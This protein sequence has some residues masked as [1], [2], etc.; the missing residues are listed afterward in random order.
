M[1]EKPKI[2]VVDDETVIISGARKILSSEG[3]EV[4]AATDAEQAMSLLP[5]AL[6]EIAFIDLMLPRL[7]GLRLLE[8]IKREYPEVVVVMMTG[9]STLDNA[10]AFL[11]GGA[12]DYLPKPFEYEELHS[13]A[14]RACRF[15]SLRSAI[16]RPPVPDK[17]APQYLLGV[18]SWVRVNRDGTAFLGITD[19]LSQ[20][21]GPIEDV[22]L[23]DVNDEI[24]Q[25]SRLA[26]VLTRD[27][28]RHTVWS[29]LSGRVIELNAAVQASWE[30]IQRDPMGEGWLV[31]ITPEDLE[32]ELVNLSASSRGLPS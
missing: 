9:Y 28:L 29:A 18:N 12:F 1:T 11:K 7:S 20:I 3:F 14:Q 15:V 2:L 16:R 22:E 10:I 31:R 21:L 32:S 19:I 8:W 13:T 30:G 5:S 26:H 27:E 23:P 25:G 4:L 6:P 24:R 17:G